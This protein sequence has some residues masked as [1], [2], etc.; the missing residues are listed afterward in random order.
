MEFRKSI[1]QLQQAD[2]CLVL[3]RRY[4]LPKNNPY[5]VPA[6]MFKM[7]F[8]MVLGEVMET[9][10][11]LRLKKHTAFFRYGS[12]RELAQEDRNGCINTAKC[13][14]ICSHT[15]ERICSWCCCTPSK[16]PS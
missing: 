16:Y 6:I 8:I 9:L 5:R 2:F 15:A 4:Y 7:R 12:A 1:L 3:K 14:S 13:K 10:S 11:M